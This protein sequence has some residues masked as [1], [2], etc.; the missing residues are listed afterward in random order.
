MQK[1]LNLLQRNIYVMNFQVQITP[2]AGIPKKIGR[3]KDG[4]V[5]QGINK[6]EMT[7]QTLEIGQ[8]VRSQKIACIP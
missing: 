4:R 7:S 1:T 8:S 2:F 6:Y 5:E 3:L